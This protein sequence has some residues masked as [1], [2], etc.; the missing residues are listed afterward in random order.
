MALGKVQMKIYLILPKADASWKSPPLGLRLIAT[1]LK[2]SGYD[3]I[4]DIDPEKGDDPYDLDYSGEDTLIGISVTFMTVGEA[5]KLARF[6]KSINRKTTVVF[7][8]PQ[9]TLVPDECLADQGVDAIALG[10]GEFTMLEIA[11]NLAKGSGFEGIR[12]VWYK[13]SDGNYCRNEPREFLADLD[14]LPMPDREFFKDSEYQK[15]RHKPTWYLMTA[16]SCPF[17]CRMCQ[18][19]LRKIAGPFR[20]RSVRNVIGEIEFLVREYGATR[21]NFY[22]NDMGINKRWMRDFCS[23]ASKI[24]GLSM[25]CCGRINVLDYEMLALMK[26]AGFDSVSFGAESGSDRVL[27]EI[28]NKGTTVRQIVDFA[29]NCYDLDVKANAFWMMANPGETLEEMKASIKLASELPTYY[30][31]FHIATP[32]PCT[33]FHIDAVDGGYLRMRTWE[34]V[35]HRNMPTIIKSNVSR[36]DIIE[37]DGHLVRTMIRKGWC[38]EQNGHTLSFYNTRLF[39]KRDLARVVKREVMVFLRDHRPYHIRNVLWALLEWAKSKFALE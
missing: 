21:L 13:D 18:P 35:N 36:Q 8:G 27:T 9:A 38:F 11:N 25:T 29:N 5:F 17:N 15:G 24:G 3:E 31:H 32:N 20:Q 14:T 19:A 34:D 12:G 6:I 4:Y 16:Q 10:E 37:M 1:V 22:D 7:G 28:M 2:I 23:A 33:S 39:A 30:C 26:K